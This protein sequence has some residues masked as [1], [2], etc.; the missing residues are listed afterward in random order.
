[1]ENVTFQHVT[2]SS[3]IVSVQLTFC[4]DSGKQVK[5]EREKMEN[6]GAMLT[7]LPNAFLCEDPR[8]VLK[9]YFCARNPVQKHK[10]A[11]RCNVCWL[12]IHYLQDYNKQ[13]SN[14]LCINILLFSLSFQN[15]NN[16]RGI[17]LCF[18]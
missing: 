8:L 18:I 3:C 15:I 1:M 13:D 16:I 7:A 17:K 10:D 2:F 4:A 9:E 6:G 14:Q 11:I 5:Y 12:I